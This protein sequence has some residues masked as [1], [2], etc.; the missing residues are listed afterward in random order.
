MRADRNERIAQPGSSGSYRQTIIIIAAILILGGLAWML[1]P[2][3]EAPAPGPVT[4][5]EPAEIT[6]AAPVREEELPAAPDIPEEITPVVAEDPNAPMEEQPVPEPEPPAITLETSDE[7]V[8]EFVAAGDPAPTLSKLLVTQNLLERSAASID[9]VR[10]GLVPAKLLNLPK[11]AGNFSTRR[12]GSSLIMDPASYDRYDPI[13]EGLLSLPPETVAAAFHE[14]RPLLEQ[15]FS[16]LGY[17][18]DEVDNA[19]I[20]A[21]DRI[22]ATPVIEE[23]IRVIPAEAV[24]AYEDPTLEGMGELEK[25]LLRTGPDNLREIQRYAKTLRGALLTP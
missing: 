23:D 8:R 10:R 4:E 5:V 20:Q 24:F 6:P 16:A 11:P 14:F 3:D 18:P 15:A 12:V 2:D 1:L 21:L 25:Q 19:L 7:P 9:S 22:I 13:V 17:A